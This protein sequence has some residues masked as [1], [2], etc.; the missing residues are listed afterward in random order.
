M[1]RMTEVS[2]T[3]AKCLFCLDHFRNS[4]K[5]QPFQPAYCKGGC[6]DYVTPPICP[7][8]EEKLLDRGSGACCE[9][10]SNLASCNP[11]VV[12]R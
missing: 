1:G 8:S 7:A 4:T 6:L 3:T 10:H 12:T 5:M 9:L 11:K 2:V